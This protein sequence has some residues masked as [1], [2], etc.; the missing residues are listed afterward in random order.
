MPDRE[1][2][3]PIVGYFLSKAVLRA[4]S[5]LYNRLSA[6]LDLLFSFATTYA[7]SLTKKYLHHF[8]SASRGSKYHEPF[9]RFTSCK[10]LFQGE[11][12][13]RN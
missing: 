2:R 8:T 13:Q 11:K 5:Y 4:P 1:T 3:S 7:V 12:V 6:Q 9:H 10:K